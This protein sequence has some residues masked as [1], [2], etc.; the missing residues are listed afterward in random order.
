V[1]GQAQNTVSQPAIA[2]PSRERVH[3]ELFAAGRDDP[4][5]RRP[6][7]E[8]RAVAYLVLLLVAAV[9]SVVGHDFDARFSNALVDLPGFLDALW[10]LGVWGAV[11][12]VAALLVIMLIRARPL[13]AGEAL[14][15]SILAIGGS[16]CVAALVGESPVDVFSRIGD[17]GAHRCSPRRCSP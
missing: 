11:V 7:D 4:R 16:A 10:L 3:A 1:N 14:V 8:I 9:L 6:S 15:A 17:S 2:T 12:W 13:L 5:A